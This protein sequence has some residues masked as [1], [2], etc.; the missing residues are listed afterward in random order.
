MS[1]AEKNAC[2][3]H[4]TLHTVFGHGSEEQ[5]SEEQLL[6]NTRQDHGSEVNCGVECIHLKAEAHPEV[7]RGN[8][9]HRNVVQDCSAF[10]LRCI[11]AV[12][13]N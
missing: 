4:C 13:L 10:A 12:V 5:S 8:E 1:H 9:N 3:Y 11:E 2:Q 7:Y 6:S